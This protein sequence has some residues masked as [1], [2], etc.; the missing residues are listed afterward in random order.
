MQITFYKYHGAGNDFIIIDNR[1]GAY[2]HIFTTERIALWCHRRF[3]IGA[4]GLILLQNA[5]SSDFKMVY[6]NADGKASTMCGNGGRCIVHFA[7]FL[8]IFDE[9]T[10]FEATDGLHKASISNGLINLGMNDVSEINRVDT[11]TYVLN[12][13]SPHYIKIGDAM[14]ANIR[15]AGSNIRYSEPYKSEGINVNFVVCKNDNLEVCTYERGVEDETYSCGTGVVASA[16]SS[17]MDAP[18]GRYSVKISTKGGNLEVTFNKSAENKYTD[19][20][21]KGPAV[22]VFKGLLTVDNG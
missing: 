19:V 15:D 21:L 10:T 17:V 16:I 4:D 8:G 7:Y 18:A 9:E 13:G 2:E 11:Q 1:A 22:Q 5:E 12:T 20:F 3:G 14:P 6:F